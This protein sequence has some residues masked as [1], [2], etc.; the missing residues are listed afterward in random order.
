MTLVDHWFSLGINLLMAFFSG[1][2][3]SPSLF[4]YPPWTTGMPSMHDMSST[5]LSN[6]RQIPQTTIAPVS[7]TQPIYS[8]QLPLTSGTNVHSS[9]GQSIPTNMGQMSIGSMVSRGK[10]LPGSSLSIGGQPLPGSSSST[11][12]KPFPRSSPLTEGKPFLGSLSSTCGK[13]FSGSS[14]APRI[15]QQILGF[16]QKP[17]GFGQQS[18]LGFGQQPPSFGQQSPPGFG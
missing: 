9:L 1:A 8:Q 7:S 6:I 17:H 15:G 3:T 13:F 12:G 4:H 5:T 10:P 11:G 16:G 2:S 18:P 14:L